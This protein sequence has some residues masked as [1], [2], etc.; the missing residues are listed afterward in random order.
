[1]FSQRSLPLSVFR[2][3]S[4]YLQSSNCFMT[5]TYSSPFAPVFPG[6]T[7]SGFRIVVSKQ[8]VDCCP[9]DWIQISDNPSRSTVPQNWES[10]CVCL[11]GMSGFG[12]E[13]QEA[14]TNVEAG[15]MTNH[16]AV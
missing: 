6:L 15:G 14:K 11:S 5:A 13:R 10:V 16:H 4:P 2:L 12:A 3:F 1:M 7:A 8:K 9:P